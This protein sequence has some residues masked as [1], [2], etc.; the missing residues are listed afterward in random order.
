MRKALVLGI[1][2]LFGWGK[3]HYEQRLTEAHRNAFFHGAKLNLSLRQQVGQFGFVAALSG[4]RSLVADLLW[5][6]AHS[7]WEATQWGRMALIYNNV[8]ALQP[9]SVD[10]WD[11]AAWQMAW[12]ASIAAR[13]DRRI[14]RQA[15]RTKA[16]HEYW[17]IGK[18]FLERGIQNNP[19]RYNLYFSLGR[20]L[21]E[22]YKDHEAASRAYAEAAKFPKA[23]VYLHRFAVY[24][25]ALTPGKE[26]EAYQQLVALYRK[27]PKERLPT[28]ISHIKRLQDALQI[29]EDQRLQLENP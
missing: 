23:P 16:E 17:D 2:L 14:P 25:L 11:T 8:T 7:A 26:M 15:L 28:L 9:R 6:R 10:F 3:L 22:K 21:E 13:E 29:P 19:D 18:D 4:F 5:I 27:G 20:L 12:N 1:L 24:Q